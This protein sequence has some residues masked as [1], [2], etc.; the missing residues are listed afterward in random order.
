M[1]RA[2]LHAHLSGCIPPHK[3]R[4]L[5]RKYNVAIPPD[6]D[7]TRDL[8]VLKP[9]NSLPDYFKPW[10]VLKRL[11]VGKECLAEMVDAAVETL[12]Q[13]GVTYVEFRKCLFNICE[14]NNISLDEGVEWLSETLSQSSERHAI[15]ANL[16]VSLQRSDF[17]LRKTRQ[18]LSALKSRKKEGVIVGVDLCGDE[19]APIEAGIAK[20]YRSAKDD[21]GLGVTIHAGEVGSLEH[22]RWAI[23]ECHADRLGHALAAG[24]C[25]RT[26]EILRQK[27][28]CVEISLISNL[29][30]GAIRTLALHPI[31]TFIRSK[32]PF[33]L[34]SDNPEVHH[35][36]LSDEY[37]LFNS[38]TSRHDLLKAMFSTQK[39]YCF[40]DGKME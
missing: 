12:A 18:L 33:V 30:T 6:F 35:S 10:L 15:K 31:F 23:E 19:D 8:Q 24:R 17:D 28:I 14:I 25:P 22:I 11:P 3:I 32:V 20:F 2:E 36:R 4:E 34:C 16:V 13:D 29:R 40:A 39:R 5:V 7:I 9:V 21:L 27:D 1:E 38:L 37:A 26:L